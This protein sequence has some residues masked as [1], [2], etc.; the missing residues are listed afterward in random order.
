M[1]SYIVGVVQKDILQH[2]ESA[3]LFYVKES[4]IILIELNSRE[5]GPRVSDFNY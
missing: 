4:E 5:S 3:S 2:L 1:V